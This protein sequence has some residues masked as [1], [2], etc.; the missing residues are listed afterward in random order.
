[1]FTT[2]T[3]ASARAWREENTTKPASQLVREADSQARGEPVDETERL[4]LEFQ[5]PIPL[6][7]TILD[8][9][10]ILKCPLNV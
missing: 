8:P 1:M 5:V 10:L 7:F 6:Y 4:V 3:H 2:G 9:K